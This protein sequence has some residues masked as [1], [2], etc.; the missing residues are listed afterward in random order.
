MGFLLLFCCRLI[1]WPNCQNDTNM[2]IKCRIIVMEKAGN[3][4]DIDKNAQKQRKK[5]AVNICQNKNCFKLLEK[6]LR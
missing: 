3:N 1:V 5:T 2:A 4:S 6:I